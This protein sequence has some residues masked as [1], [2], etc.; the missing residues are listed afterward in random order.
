M[1]CRKAHPTG[2]TVTNWATPTPKRV[3]IESDLL[4]TAPNS[5]PATEGVLGD[6]T[7][8]GDD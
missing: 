7:F 6:A 1:F 5:I 2:P 3:P 8:A 4:A